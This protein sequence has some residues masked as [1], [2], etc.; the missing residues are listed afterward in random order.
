M[1]FRAIVSAQS[2]LASTRRILATLSAI[3]FVLLAMGAM[4]VVP[5]V[6]SYLG[7]QGT[8]ELVIN[9]ARWPL[10]LIVVSLALAVIYR[11]GPS[12]ERARWRWITWGSAFAAL[13]WLGGSALFSWYAYH[14][15][16][17]LLLK[18][19]STPHLQDCWGLV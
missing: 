5:V 16:H 14:G 9:I 12:R 11:Y 4:V 13:C 2:G 10:L 7:L 18:E 6:L 1:A 17:S 8:T 19:R 15:C 3:V